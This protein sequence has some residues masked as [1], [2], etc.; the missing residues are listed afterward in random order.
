MKNKLQK[1]IDSFPPSIKKPDI[2]NIKLYKKG[3]SPDNPFGYK[4][5]IALREQMV[6]TEPLRKLLQK[7]PAEIS[8]Q[9]IEDTAVSA[10]MLTMLHN[11]I[12]KLIGGETTVEEVFRV[13]G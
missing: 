9:M 3:S 7:P 12:Y 10:G 11:A 8:A 1:I 4:G 5:Q 6:M 13:L 2:N